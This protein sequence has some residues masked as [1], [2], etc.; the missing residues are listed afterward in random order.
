MLWPSRTL[1]AEV[2]GTF[3]SFALDDGSDILSYASL[4]S[5]HALLAQLLQARLAQLR[6]RLGR[7]GRVVVMVVHALRIA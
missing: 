5:S 3:G 2:L 1:C 6:D 7:L 4:L